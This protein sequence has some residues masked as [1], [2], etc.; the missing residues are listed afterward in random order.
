GESLFNDG[1][2]G[3]LYQT[4]LALVLLTLHGQAPSGLAA[5][6]NGLVLFVVEA[7][8][9]LA[10]GGLAGFLISQ[11]LKRIDDPV[12]ETTITL[13]SAYG[14]YWVANA[15]HLSAIIAVIV[16]ALI[17]GNY[18]QAIGMSARTRSD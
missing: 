11:G 3:S 6:G 9:G 1:V 18:G 15:V 10:L 12:L 4:F 16:T 7:G 13:L 2:A 8:G 14:I 5:F 17:L